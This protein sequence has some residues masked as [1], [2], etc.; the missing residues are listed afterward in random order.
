MQDLQPKSAT[1]DDC[2]D[3]T[4]DGCIE[5]RLFSMHASVYVSAYK[6]KKQLDLH[7]C[8]PWENLQISE[9][10]SLKV[11]IDYQTGHR[12]HQKQSQRL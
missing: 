8:Q 6:Q 5:R 1:A 12:S 10:T 7:C 2:P 3:L 11:N 9:L 4:E